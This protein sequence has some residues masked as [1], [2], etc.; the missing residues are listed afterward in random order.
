MIPSLWPDMEKWAV[1]YLTP[2]NAGVIVANIFI[3]PEGAFKQVFVTATPGP[4]ITAITQEVRLDF[5]VRVRDANG[6]VQLFDQQALAATIAYQIESAPRDSN[7]I[8]HAEKDTGPT[9]VT[10]PA[11]GPEFHELTV[12]V[13]VHRT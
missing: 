1:D 2:Q 10:D 13:E 4:R 6:H 5:E 7:P 12:V 11:G 9:R 3:E 8:V